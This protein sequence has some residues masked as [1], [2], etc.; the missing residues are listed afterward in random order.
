MKRLR[1]L[2]SITNDEDGYQIEQASTGLAAA[3]KLGIDIDIVYAGND[4]IKQSQ[5]LL[6]CI[7]S[8]ATQRTDAILFEPAGSTAHPQVARA[9]AAAGM[10]V[11]VLNREANYI[12]ELRHAFN[13]PAFAITSNHDEI[14][15]IQ[16]QQLNSL[17]PGGGVVLYIHGPAE[18]SAAKQRHLATMQTKLESINLRVLKAQWSEVS[19]YKGV[20]SWLR[21]STSN[22][23]KIQAVC[24]QD[25][26]MAMGAR[27]AFE[28]CYGSK[29]KWKDIPFLG[30]DG[31]AKAGQEWVRRNLLAATIHIPPNSGMGMEMM[32]KSIKTGEM[33]LERTFTLAK[34]I[35]SPEALAATGSAR[36]ATV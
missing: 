34:P 15:R 2:L 14:G 30:C 21:L 23:V 5:Q 31:M 26:S 6:S 22:Q 4:G 29:D 11:V 1:F 19:A 12:S 8:S 17:V 7:Q 18:S 32:A 13:V 33:P 3:K 35:P 20:C 16:G 25:D 27:K 28:E 10:G 36:V 9:A 24:A